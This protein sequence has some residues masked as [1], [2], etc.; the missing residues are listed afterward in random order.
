MGCTSVELKYVVVPGAADCT[1]RLDFLDRF[2]GN[3]GSTSTWGQRSRILGKNWEEC[4]HVNPMIVASLRATA[5]ASRKLWMWMAEGDRR[6]SVKR[7]K[8]RTPGSVDGGATSLLW[9]NKG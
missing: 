6:K 3:L 1:D 5:E 7:A 8:T 9:Y 2:F 4:Y